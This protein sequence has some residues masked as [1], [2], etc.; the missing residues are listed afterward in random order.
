MTANEKGIDK[1]HQYDTGT[2]TVTDP[3]G[4]VIA[5]GYVYG[6]GNDL[7]EV[8]LVRENEDFPMRGDLKVSID[9][10]RTWTSLAAFKS[11]AESEVGTNSSK[12][13]ATVNYASNWDNAPAPLHA[14]SA[15]ADDAPGLSDDPVDGWQYDPGTV[16]ITGT[17]PSD[18]KNT[19][20]LAL[21]WVDEV[22]GKTEELWALRT[23]VSFPLSTGSATTWTWTKYKPTSR[24]EFRGAAKYAMGGAAIDE[25]HVELKYAPP[26]SGWSNADNATFPGQ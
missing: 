13:H 25:R 6:Q 16:T 21:V 24:A 10:T 8:W 17:D 26:A 23:G 12:H 22:G 15:G 4:Q 19:V 2:V 7:D 9:G 1:F 3:A 5:V 14:G 20:V 18:P 11:H